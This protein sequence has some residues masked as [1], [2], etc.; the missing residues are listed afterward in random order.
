MVS[1]AVAIAGKIRA[2][3]ELF[4]MSKVGTWIRCTVVNIGAF[5]TSSLPSWIAIAFV[6]ALRIGTCCLLVAS[7]G[8]F[9][10]VDIFA[11]DLRCKLKVK[12]KKQKFESMMR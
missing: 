6:G 1:C 3:C 12:N 4:A 2:I 11:A 10:L 5:E 7:K 8:V 9:T